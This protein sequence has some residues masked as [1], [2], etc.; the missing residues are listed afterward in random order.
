MGDWYDKSKEIGPRVEGRGIRVNRETTA[1]R[2][3]EHG[4]L[5]LTGE[6]CAHIVSVHAVRG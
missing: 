2:A 6:A 4:I 1:G 3:E 5:V